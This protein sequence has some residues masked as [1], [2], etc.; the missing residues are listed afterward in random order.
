VISGKDIEWEGGMKAERKGG[1]RG[2][3]VEGWEGRRE[4]IYRSDGERQE[5]M[6]E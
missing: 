3:R 5:E 6:K 1:R 2:R 4:G